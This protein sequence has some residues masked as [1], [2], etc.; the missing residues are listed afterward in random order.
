MASPNEYPEFYGRSVAASPADV[1]SRFITQTYLHLYGAI[2]AF[3]GLETLLMNL[4]GIDQLAGLMMSSRI[5]WLVVL[6]LFMVVSMR[7]VS[8][9]R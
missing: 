9:S 5:G 7:L 2:L 6:G 1:R 3:A 4:P 8:R